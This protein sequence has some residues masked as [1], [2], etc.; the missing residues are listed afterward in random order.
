VGSTEPAAR[1]LEKQAFVVA[2]WVWRTH[3]G[4]R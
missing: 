4:R 2:R 3:S 1:G